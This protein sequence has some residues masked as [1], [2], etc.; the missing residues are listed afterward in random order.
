MQGTI[1]TPGVIHEIT[2]LIDAESV[3]AGQNALSPCNKSEKV[4]V[5]F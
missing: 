2:T 1:I 3:A 5:Q 4:V